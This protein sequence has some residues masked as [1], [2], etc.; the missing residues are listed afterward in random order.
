MIDQLKRYWIALLVVA[1]VLLHGA[2]V[3]MIRLEATAAKQNASCEVDL[4]TY[5]VHGSDT[6]GPLQLRVHSLSPVN[7]RMQARRLIE[8]NQYQIRQAIEE[9]L[10]QTPSEMLQDPVLSDLKLQLLDI[11]I[12]TVGKSSVEEI[13]VTEF[14]PVDERLQWSFGSPSH[15]NSPRV[16]ITRREEFEAAEAEAEAKIA[17][18]AAQSDSGHG[19][20]HGGGHGE[21]TNDAHGGS[22]GHGGAHAEDGHGDSGHGDSGGHAAESGHH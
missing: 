4:G 14:R 2:I 7:H 1:L 10:R 5:V 16:V 3:A 20:G 11:M 21:D 19:G 9:Y 8:L 22:S 13:L 17:E 18:Q 6:V 12:Q 15:H